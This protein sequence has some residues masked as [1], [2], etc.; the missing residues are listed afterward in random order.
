MPKWILVNVV[1]LLTLLAGILCAHEPESAKYVVEAYRLEPGVPA[2]KI[3]G[4]LDDPA[5]QKAK[6]VSGFH[7]TGARPSQTRHRRYGIL[8]RLR[9]TPPLRRLSVL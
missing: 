9:P 2:P 1:L 3:D 5:W 7:S 8:Y 6:P 4:K